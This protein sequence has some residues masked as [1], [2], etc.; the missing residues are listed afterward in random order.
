V[1]LPAQLLLVFALSL[2]ALVGLIGWLQNVNIIT[3]NGLYKAIQAEPW[4]ADFA[5]ARLDYANY[6]YFPLYGALAHL[7]DGLGILRGVAFKQFAYLNAFFASL[8]VVFVYGFVHRLT[9]NVRAAIAAALFHLGTGFFLLLGVISEDIMPG[10][11][12]V[13]VSMLLAGLWFDRPTSR[14]I[15]GVSA[16]FTVGWLV[17]WRLMFPTLPAFVLALLLSE[18]D[19]KVRARRVGILLV[20]V[21]ASAGIVEV[22][23]E[24]HNGAIGLPD[25]LW[26]GKAVTSGWAGLSWDKAWMMLSGVGNY[27]LIV[28]G[29]V[30]PLSARRAVV[31]LLVSVALEVAIFA[32]CIAF[33]W[34]RRGERRLRATAIVFLGTLGAGQAMNFYAQPQD[35]QMQINVM[36]WLTIAWALLVAALLARRPRLWPL[37]AL[38]SLAP[39]AWNVAALSKWRGGDTAALAAMAALERDLPPDRTVFVYWGFEPITT[40]QFML[41]SRTPDW[42][43]IA[44]IGRAPVADPKFK[45]ISIDTGAIRHPERPADADART[46][47][48][49]IDQALDLGYRVAIS[50]VWTWDVNEL[51]GQLGGLSAAGHAPAIHAALHDNYEATPVLSDPFAGAYFELRRKSAPKQAH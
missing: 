20:S 45:W 28:G 14:Q 13:L 39:L 23:W 25:L 42:D 24:G 34:P 6:L 3:G 32:A 47:R 8:A 16:I 40:W 48:H 9:G 35:P 18:G 12:L 38:V 50:D 21:L 7:L 29:F 37:V 11:F 30:D 10:Y 49:D 43:G 27:F 2:L 33:L 41:W 46:I 1:R 51:A 22:C 4:I 19:W 5:H 36:P 26:T 44:S 31:P 17:E 15:A